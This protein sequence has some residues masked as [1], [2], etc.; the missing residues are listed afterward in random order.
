MRISILPSPHIMPNPKEHENIMPN[1]KEH[2][3]IMPNPKDRVFI[4]FYCFILTEVI[5]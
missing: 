3:N 1:P 5:L 4:L 2:E